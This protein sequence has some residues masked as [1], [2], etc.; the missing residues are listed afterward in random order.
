MLDWAGECWKLDC[1]KLLLSLGHPVW[2]GR[3]C[4]TGLLTPGGLN[5]IWGAVAASLSRI[6]IN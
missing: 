3:L 5:A 4:L 6:C 1:N 2:A